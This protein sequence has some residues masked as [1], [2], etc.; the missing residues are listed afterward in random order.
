MKLI[1]VVTVSLFIVQKT[2]TV[3]FAVTVNFLL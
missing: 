1:C 2:V 3:N